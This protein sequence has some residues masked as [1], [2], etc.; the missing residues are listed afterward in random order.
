MRV[1]CYRV[2]LRRRSMKEFLHSAERSALN[3]T[4]CFR[5][6]SIPFRACGR[7]ES[8]REVVGMVT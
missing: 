4:A 2:S 6:C 7:D 5:T 1:A 8:P 3:V